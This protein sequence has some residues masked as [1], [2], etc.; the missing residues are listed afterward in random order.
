MSTERLTSAKVPIEQAVQRIFDLYALITDQFAQFRGE[1][2]SKFETMDNR[3]EELSASLLVFR[4]GISTRIDNIQAE[5][6]E[7]NIKSTAAIE[8][9]RQKIRN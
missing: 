9:C 1:I 8:E 4:E 3:Y 5:T 2:A 6:S 7:W